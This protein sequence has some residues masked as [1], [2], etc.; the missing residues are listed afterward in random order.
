MRMIDWNL[1]QNLIGLG[2]FHSQ[3]ERLYVLGSGWSLNEISDDQ[4]SKIRNFGDTI[5]F[6]DIFRLQNTY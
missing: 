6:N 1:T 4:W 2:E 3:K 5:G